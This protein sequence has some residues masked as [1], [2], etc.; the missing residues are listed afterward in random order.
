MK[1]TGQNLLKYEL[2]IQK[3]C[4]PISWKFRSIKAGVQHLNHHAFQHKITP[5]KFCNK[6]MPFPAWTK[7]TQYN[8][9][10]VK[11]LKFLW[12]NS[13]ITFSRHCSHNLH[14]SLPPNHRQTPPE[15]C[16]W[17]VAATSIS[18]SRADFFCRRACTWSS[19][20]CIDSSNFW[21]SAILAWKQTLPIYSSY[22]TTINP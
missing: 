21:S 8:L 14:F 1:W 6:E 12:L 4:V 3:T 11:K 20:D 15:P 10:L 18:W 5:Q 17:A 9:P 19:T 13:Q 22:T 2:Q 7:I 16:L